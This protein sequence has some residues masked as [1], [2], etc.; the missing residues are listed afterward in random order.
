MSIKTRIFIKLKNIQCL[1]FISKVQRVQVLTRKKWNK[2]CPRREGQE[3]KW[4]M[5]TQKRQCPAEHQP[6]NRISN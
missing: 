6:C 2:H 1:N 5:A 3:K 4:K